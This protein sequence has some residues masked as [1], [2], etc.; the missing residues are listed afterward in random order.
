MAA[1]RKIL[2]VRRIDKIRKEDI[3]VKTGCV[4]IVVQ[5]V[6]ERQ[7]KRLENVLRMKNNRIARYRLQLIT[8]HARSVLD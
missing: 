8:E 5:I 7:H 6:Y 3:R 2:G 1:L 4:K